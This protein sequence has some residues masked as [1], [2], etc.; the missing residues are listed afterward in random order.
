MTQATVGTKEERPSS[1]CPSTLGSAVGITK[2]YVGHSILWIG[3]LL[4]CA[5]TVWFLM[6]T[7]VGVSKHSDPVIPGRPSPSNLSFHGPDRSVTSLSKKEWSSLQLLEHRLT[8]CDLPYRSFCGDGTS[9]CNNWSATASVVSA[10]SPF[11][12]SAFFP[13]SWQRLLL[14]RGLWRRVARGRLGRSSA[15]A[16]AAASASPRDSRTLV[17]HFS[18]L[19]LRTLVL[20]FC[21]MALSPC[22]FCSMTFAAPHVP[23]SMP[24]PISMITRSCRAAC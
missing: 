20:F 7:T 24:M 1:S 9:V 11:S 6:P 15:C 13:P 4:Y 23:P 12:L 16:A 21:S 17:F 14:Y 2:Q 18:I 22:L 8:G 5:C 19:F 3:Q 10:A